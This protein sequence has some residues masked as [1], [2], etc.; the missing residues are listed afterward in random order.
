MDRDVLISYLCHNVSLRVTKWPCRICWLE[1]HRIFSRRKSCRIWSSVIPKVLHIPWLLVSYGENL[2]CVSFCIC[3]PLFITYMDGGG[4]VQK[5]TV[6][7]PGSECDWVLRHPVNMCNRNGQNEGG[8]RGISIHPLT[9]CYTSCIYI[10]NYQKWENTFK[11]MTESMNN[12]I[13]RA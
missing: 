5:Q 2:W 4:Q 12:L 7:P 10:E 8:V 6:Q 13:I 9:Q 3:L 11:F 1:A